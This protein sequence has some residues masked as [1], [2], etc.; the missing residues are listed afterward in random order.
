MAAAL[1]LCAAAQQPSPGRRITPV[2]PVRGVNE[3]QSTVTY[4]DSIWGEN[5]IEADTIVLPRVVGNIY[6]LLNGMTIGVNLWDAAMRIGGQKY[7]LGSVKAEVSLHNRYFP[8]AEAGLSTAAYRPDGNNYTFRSPLAPFVKI[9]AGYN[10]FY[11]SDPAY[12]LC[13][14]MAYGVSAFSF[15]TTDVMIDEGY[16]RDPAHIELPSQNTVAGWL[17]VG[18]ALKVRIAGPVSAGWSLTYRTVLH[19]GTGRYGP[20]VIIPGVGK[21][22]SPIGI[23]VYVTYDLPWPRSRTVANES[24]LMNPGDPETVEPTEQE[25][26]DL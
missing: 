24:G 1:T 10:I 12:R 23:G 2:A 15:R 13:F 3:N 11:N 26:T 4:V 8:F 17:E 19:G 5:G 14:Y 6:P 7:G 9:G 18:A 22:N 21:R 25:N 16:W 20:A